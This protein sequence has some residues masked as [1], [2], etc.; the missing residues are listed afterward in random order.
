MDLAD[1]PALLAGERFAVA[2][3]L[4]TPE[5]TSPAA[6]EYAGDPDTQNVVLEG[7]EGYLSLNG[8]N[9]QNTEQSFGTNVCLKAYTQEELS[10]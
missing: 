9:W 8:K 5:N 10:E 6:V 2:V 3:K 4:E 7:K 1:K